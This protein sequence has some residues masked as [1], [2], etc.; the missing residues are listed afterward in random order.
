MCVTSSPNRIFNHQEIIGVEVH[1]L[2]VVVK[3]H[4]STKLTAFVV[5]GSAFVRSTLLVV[6]HPPTQECYG[7]QTGTCSLA[8]KNVWQPPRRSPEDTVVLTSINTSTNLVGP[9]AS[10]LLEH[11]RIL[12]IFFHNLLRSAPPVSPSTPRMES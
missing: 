11:P 9:E 7:I 3:G 2:P 8:R 1:F 12:L 6:Y 4:F 5:L 10:D